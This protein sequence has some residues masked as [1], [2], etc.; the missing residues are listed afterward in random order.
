VEHVLVER[1][2]YMMDEKKE[3]VF[4]ADELE[5]NGHCII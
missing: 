2:A 3:W 5:S 4:L 1:T